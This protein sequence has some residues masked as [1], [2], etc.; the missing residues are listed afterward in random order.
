MLEQEAGDD[1]AGQP[2]GEGA[3]EPRRDPLGQ[4]RWLGRVFR[5]RE[6]ASAPCRSGP[7]RRRA[8]TAA[9]AAPSAI[10]PVAISG[11]GTRPDDAQQREQTLCR[12]SSSSMNDARRR[13]ASVPWSTSASALAR[14]LRAPPRRGT[15]TETATPGLHPRDHALR[16]A[17]E[18]DRDDG[19]SLVQIS[20][21]LLSQSCRHT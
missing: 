13:L 18:H 7:S 12:A 15:V 21:S 10:P 8:R 17:A 14:A 4:D 11:S 5:L 2:P 16:P 20:S 9:S 6:P 3:R 19:D 1:A